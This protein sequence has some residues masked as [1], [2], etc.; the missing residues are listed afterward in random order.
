MAT[1]T[2]KVNV[3]SKVKQLRFLDNL[4]AFPGLRLLHQQPPLLPHQRNT[5]LLQQL[6]FSL[7]VLPVTGTG[8]DTR[9]QV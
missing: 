6:R 3:N 8:C 7:L 5:L 9:L 4:V 2:R 1:K